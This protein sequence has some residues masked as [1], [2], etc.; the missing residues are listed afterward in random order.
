MANSSSQ[1]AYT[2]GKAAKICMCSR[3]TI[4]NCCAKEVI[5]S[6]RL[7]QSTHRRIPSDRLYFFMKEQGIPTDNFPKKDIP[8]DAL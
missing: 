8:K 3:H 6:Y 2:T 1:K 4:L 7:P 5:P